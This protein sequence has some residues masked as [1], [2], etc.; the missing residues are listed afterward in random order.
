MLRRLVASSASKPGSGLRGCHLDGHNI[1]NGWA[2]IT[3]D[4]GKRHGCV[5]W[6]LLSVKPPVAIHMKYAPR[7]RES[8]V[9][10]SNET[11]SSSQPETR[12]TLP[13]AAGYMLFETLMAH[14]GELDHA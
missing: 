10:H 13:A 2:S 9:E 8:C 4:R 1:L 3:I 11:S 14:E 6:A 12:Q 5:V 7:D